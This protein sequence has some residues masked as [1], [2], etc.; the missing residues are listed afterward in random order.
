MWNIGITKSGSVESTVYTVVGKRF[1]NLQQMR[2]LKSGTHLLL[3][4]R[5]RALGGTFKQK[6]EERYPGMKAETQ[7]KA[8]H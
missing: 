1:C 7:N 2:W 3:Q 4:A 6:F 5:M 8:L